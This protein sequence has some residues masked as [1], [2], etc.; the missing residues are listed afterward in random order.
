MG[1]LADGVYGAMGVFW[2]VRLLFDGGILA[3]GVFLLV[4][5]MV[6]GVISLTGHLGEAAFLCMGG[7]GGDSLLMGCFVLAV[8]SL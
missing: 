7:E 4:R 5:Y 1:H 3:G 2:C 6:D 8:F